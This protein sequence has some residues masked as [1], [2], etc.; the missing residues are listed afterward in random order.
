MD[1]VERIAC[2]ADS[3]QEAERDF[4][5]AGF[6]AGDLPLAVVTKGLAKECDTIKEIMRELGLPDDLKTGARM[7]RRRPA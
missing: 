3:K 4:R 5:F 6:I 2:I 7:R 1:D